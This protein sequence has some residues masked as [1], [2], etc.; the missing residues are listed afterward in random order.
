MGPY[1]ESAYTRLGASLSRISFRRMLP[2]LRLWLAALT[3]AVTFLKL[4]IISYPWPSIPSDECIYP[5][6]KS[7]CGF[8][9]DEAHYIP[10]VRRMMRGEGGVNL[11]HPP[12]AKLLIMAGVRLIGDNPIGWRLFI[13]LSGAASIYLVG[14]VAQELT[15][16]R[17]ISFVA[18]SLFAFDITSFNLGSMAILDPPT[19]MFSLLGTLL[20]LRR[21]CGLAG[22][23]FGLA[24]LCKLTASFI[25][26]AVL[27][28]RLALDVSGSRDIR[29]G[30]RTWMAVFERT[31][32]IAAAV[33]L[34]GLALYDHY[35][36]VFHTPFEHVDF[37]LR[38]HSGL[39]YSESDEVYLPL[40]WTNPLQQFP[41]T[42]YF[43]VT[44]LVDGREYHT[45]A[46]YGM[47]TPLWWMTWVVA[48]FSAY[49]LFTHLGG[50]RS[51]ITHL[52]IL[53]W[54]SL[55]YLI[56]FPAG[57][58]LRRWVYPFYFYMTVPAIAIGLSNML[59]GDL[60]SEIVLYA[61]LGMQLA[62]FIIF[63]PVKPIWFLQILEQIGISP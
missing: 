57:Y 3:I 51:R 49:G 15:G 55:T 44:V 58:I 39:T 33:F 12:L 22:L 47:Q 28:M 37:M 56:Y 60:V 10:A 21:R 31:L 26:A 17:R 2:S 36:H 4:A 23:A 19:L 43:L 34:A 41:R 14:L 38:Y 18:A 30:L 24:L 7:E 45:I 48:A 63:F 25:L 8:I 54:F 32:F 11:E 46:Y 20:F 13:T 59:R 27:L 52:F 16:D 40:S 62:W 35:Y 9:F 50:A 29:D 5:P 53:S 1:P 61:V 6:I 42:P